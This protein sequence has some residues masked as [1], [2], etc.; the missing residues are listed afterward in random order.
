MEIKRNILYIDVGRCTEC[1]GCH[2]VAPEI[3][4]LNSETGLM[5]VVDFE[6]YDLLLVEEAIKNCPKDCIKWE[7]NSN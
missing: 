7:E 3:F 2:E 4:R 5:E 6:H 1:L